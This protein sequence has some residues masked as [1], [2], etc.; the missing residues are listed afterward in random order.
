MA[1]Y[2]QPR[3]QTWVSHITGLISGLGR[4]SGEGNGYPLQYSDPE[5]SMYCTVH[6]VRKSWTRLKDFRM[7]WV[8]AMQLHYCN[9]CMLVVS[10]GGKLTPRKALVLLKSLVKKR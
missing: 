2:F 1:A 5:N 8:S 10:S 7:Y 4:S 3:D 9:S 6:G